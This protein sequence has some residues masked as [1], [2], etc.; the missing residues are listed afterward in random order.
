MKLRHKA[1][2]TIVEPSVDWVAQAM[3]ESGDY[4]EVEKKPVVKKKAAKKE[5]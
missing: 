5:A 2:G 1:T 3:K 4:E